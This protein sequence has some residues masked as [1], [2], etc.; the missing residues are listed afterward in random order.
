MLVKKFDK[1]PAKFYCEKCDYYGFRESQWKRHL[2]TKK[3]N[4]SD[5]SKNASKKVHYECACGKRYVHDTSYYRHVKSCKYGEVG[6]VGEVE[7]SSQSIVKL[8]CDVM[9]Q[10]KVLQE[11][12]LAIL[13]R[14]VR[15]RL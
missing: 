9:T 12:M 11:Q 14:C 2:Q 15:C 6:E 5:A 10:N 8:L 1:V 7:E 4:A 13:H 3:H